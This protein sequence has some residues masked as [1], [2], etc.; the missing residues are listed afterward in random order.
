VLDALTVND[1]AV[2]DRAVIDRAVIDRPGKKDSVTND[3]TDS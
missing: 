3:L 1:R 2:I